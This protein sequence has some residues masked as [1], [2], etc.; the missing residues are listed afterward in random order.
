MSSNVQVPTH[1]GT[2]L[3]NNY[4]YLRHGNAQ[5][6]STRNIHFISVTSLDTFQLLS[7]CLKVSF[8]I[9]CSR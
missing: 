1:C 9:R 4:T 2:G 8:M 3:S 6:N 7:G 5:K